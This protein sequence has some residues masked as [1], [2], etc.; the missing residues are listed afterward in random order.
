MKNSI[1]TLVI[2]TTISFSYNTVLPAAPAAR[3]S[4]KNLFQYSK[5]QTVKNASCFV[6]GV[7]VVKAQI[8][9]GYQR[10]REKTDQL[11]QR[12]TKKYNQ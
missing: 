7:A 1:F 9:S 8:D 3:G 5:T 11:R 2:V 4:I 12:Y 10:N 6:G